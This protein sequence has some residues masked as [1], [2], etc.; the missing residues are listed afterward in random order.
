MSLASA[1]GA[2][3]TSGSKKYTRSRGRAKKAVDPYPSAYGVVPYEMFRGG[4]W[5]RIDDLGEAAAGVYVHV[6]GTV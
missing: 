3:N 4:P 2:S 6:F 5:T 1:A